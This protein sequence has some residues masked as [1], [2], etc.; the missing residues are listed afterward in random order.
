MPFGVIYLGVYIIYYHVWKQ[1]VI[2]ADD[3]KIKIIK[4]SEFQN[5]LIRGGS[6]SKGMCQSYILIYNNQNSNKTTIA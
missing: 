1:K 4:I 5:Q 6:E 2:S 3:L